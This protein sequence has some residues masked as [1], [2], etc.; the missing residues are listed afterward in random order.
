MDSHKNIFSKL[1][2][3]QVPG[4]LFGKI[5]AKISKK[6]RRRAL[7]E[8]VVSSTFFVG[9]LAFFVPVVTAV[10]NAMVQSGSYEYFALVFSNFSEVLSSWQD[11]ASSFLESLPILG[12]AGFLITMFVLLASLRFIS[13]DAKILFYHHS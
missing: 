12:I 11:F 6:Q 8:F 5:M 1:P 10:H 13:R 2:S 4:E 7:W 9:A 3:H